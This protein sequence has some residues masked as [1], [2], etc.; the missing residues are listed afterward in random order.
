MPAQQVW[1]TPPQGTQ[2]P[3]TQ[4]V[5]VPVQLL[6]AQQGWPLAPQATHDEPEQSAPVLHE[7]PQQ[8]W[9]AA[10]QRLQVLVAAAQTVPVPQTCPLQQGSVLAPHAAH[11]DEVEQRNPDA[12]LVCAQQGCPLPPQLPQVPFMQI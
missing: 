6:P 11:C 7:V 10:P 9:P 8:S 4:A 5:E 12:Q 3:L 2:L 1:L